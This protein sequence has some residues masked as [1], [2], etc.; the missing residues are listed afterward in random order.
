MLDLH[1]SL[2]RKYDQLHGFSLTSSSHV[3][4]KWCCIATL[5]I[6]KSRFWKFGFYLIGSTG[7]RWNQ[8]Q[9]IYHYVNKCFS[10]KWKVKIVYS[11]KSD[12]KDRSDCLPDYNYLTSRETSS[13][14]FVKGLCRGTISLYLDLWRCTSICF[15]LSI[16]LKYWR[17][18]VRFKIVACLIDCL[19]AWLVC[20]VSA[21]FQLFT[22]KWNVIPFITQLCL[23]WR[24]KRMKKINLVFT[25]TRTVFTIRLQRK[26]LHSKWTIKLCPY[27]YS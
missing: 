26:L 6:D 25:P 13:P 10:L 23:L 3:M 15:Q 20:V 14:N 16:A 8:L 1:T 24:Y 7:I 22:R 21:I 5:Y 2:R 19:L 18:C 17:C 12:W 11:L 4:V 27:P 9:K